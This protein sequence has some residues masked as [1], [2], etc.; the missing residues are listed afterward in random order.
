M[1][2]LQGA[3]AARTGLFDGCSLV[4]VATALTL[5]NLALLKNYLHYQDAELL[6]IV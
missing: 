3:G 5:P 6:L 4:R 1:L 2:R